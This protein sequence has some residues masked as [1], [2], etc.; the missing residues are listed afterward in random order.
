MNAPSVSLQEAQAI[1]E[2]KT[3]PRVTK[4]SIE[5]KIRG[6]EYVYHGTMTIAIIQMHSGFKQAGYAAPADE[7]NFDPDVGMR[8]AYED[9]FKG[10]W[11]LEGYLLCE[12]LAAGDAVPTLT[13][14]A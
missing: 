3:A 10:L 6:V 14:R 5:A 2:T 12:R 8:Y 9:A 11:K 13:E 1:V 7:R 4:E